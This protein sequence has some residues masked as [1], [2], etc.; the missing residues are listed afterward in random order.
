MTAETPP[1]VRRVSGSSNPDD[2]NYTG[3]GYVDNEG[4]YHFPDGRSLPVTGGIDYPDGR[5]TEGAVALIVREDATPTT[6]PS[7]DGANPIWSALQ[8]LHCVDRAQ[9]DTYDFAQFG[10][11]GGDP[12]VEPLTEALD[13]ILPPSNAGTADPHGPAV[14][15][16]VLGSPERE[17]ALDA[18]YRDHPERHR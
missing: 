12:T 13:P 6:T 2:R 15:A 3:L 5:H 14:K 9:Q 16:F 4:A 8:R 17:D 10:V 1:N 18:S 11:L 7:A